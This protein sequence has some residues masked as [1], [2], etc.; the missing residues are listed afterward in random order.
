MSG[1]ERCPGCHPE[2][3]EGSLRPSSQT[4]RCAQGDSQYL[5]MS[6]SPLPHFGIAVDHLG[7]IFSAQALGNKTNLPVAVGAITDAIDPLPIHVEIKRTSVC[8]DGNQVRLVRVSVNR[9][10]KILSHS[11]TQSLGIVLCVACVEQ[12]GV[13][14]V[15]EGVQAVLADSEEIVFCAIAPKSDPT[16]VARDNL[17]LHL[18]SEIDWLT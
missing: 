2:R 3:S 8:H 4:L 1:L 11:Q 5:Q 9:W 18:K 10:Q 15:L 17:Y 6:A 13:L 7:W 12:Q 16:T 14:P